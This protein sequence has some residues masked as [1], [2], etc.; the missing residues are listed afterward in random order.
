MLMFALVPGLPFLQFLI[1]GVGLLIAAWVMQQRQKADIQ[2]GVVS[3]GEAEP[4]LQEETMADIL[5]IDDIHVQFAPDLVD[6]V[7]DSGTGL[8]ARIRNMRI[9]V[10]REFGV[11]MPEI[12]LTDDA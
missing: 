3:V 5:D 11:V 1:G 2:P 7:L 6:M 12:R 10:A 4:A 9:H 8:D